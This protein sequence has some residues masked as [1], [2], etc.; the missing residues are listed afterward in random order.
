MQ[1]TVLNFVI[2]RVNG[3]VQT[4]LPHLFRRD[5]P[6]PIVVPDAVGLGEAHVLFPQQPLLPFERPDDLS[7]PLK[8]R[9]ELRQLF[10][11]R[12]F[13]DP[14]RPLVVLKH[15]V[16]LDLHAHGVVIQVGHD[17]DHA[18]MFSGAPFDLAFVPGQEVPV[19]V[20]FLRG[21]KE[22]RGPL[23]GGP[24]NRKVLLSEVDVGCQVEVLSGG[25][26]METPRALFKRFLGA[27]R[28]APRGHQAPVAPGEEEVVGHVVDGA[29]PVLVHVPVGQQV[30]Q[31]AEQEHPRHVHG[32]QVLTILLQT[33]H[34]LSILQ[35]FHWR[36]YQI[37]PLLLA[38]FAQPAVE[39]V[40]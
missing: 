6:L 37:A 11:V 36:C 15:L 13:L 20:G 3:L 40:S 24:E 38:A 7:P 23:A 34:V 12:L 16:E 35:S 9:Q 30:P 2:R 31:L 8:V 22:L 19:H 17:A 33:L 1:Y 32:N 25:P 18:R 5:D 10:Q 29:D 27:L 26:V 39:G 21:A 4:G 14:P 28:H